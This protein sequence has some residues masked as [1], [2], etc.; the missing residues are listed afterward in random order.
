MNDS[1]SN[2][3]S[4]NLDR[5]NV[6]QEPKE[7]ALT[8]LIEENQELSNQYEEIVARANTLAVEVEIARLEFDQI[9]DAV[10]DPLWVVDE[11]NN[12][13]RINKSFLDHLKLEHKSAALGKK[14]YEIL[15]SPICQTEKCPM[16]R[17]KKGSKRV[18]MDIELEMIAG[19]NSAYWL[20]GTPLYGL[21]G[22]TLGVVEHFKEITERK[23]HEKALKD[24]NKE[25]EKLAVTD[26]LTQLAN[27]RVFDEA[28]QKE[29]LRMRRDQ[30]PL[31]V[32]LSDIDS[33][34]RYND[35]YGHQEGDVCLKE[36]ANCIQAS[37]CRPGDMVARYGGEEFVVILPN[38]ASDGAFQ[39]A[40]KI[41]SSIASLK[42]EHARSDVAEFVT[43]SLGVATIIPPVNGGN[44]EGLVKTADDALYASKEA[45]R[46]RVTV[47]DLG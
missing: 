18:E 13:L 17:I 4:N 36:V 22:E 5:I 32:I 35:H 15:A 30:Q 43:I 45:G 44:P 34:K 29:W 23:S 40:E 9:F 8:T 2:R 41:R 12:I 7:D 21:A 26:G 42:R 11:E 20:T 24:A 27:R 1:Q 33:F 14:C 6:A 46:N 10:G 16:T 19:D 38:T 3:K 39:V 37:V 31:S 47:R 25:L 28:L